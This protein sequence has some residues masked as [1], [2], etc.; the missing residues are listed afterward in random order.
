MTNHLEPVTE[1]TKCDEC[2][3]DA[4]CTFVSD[5]CDDNGNVNSLSLCDTCLNELVNSPFNV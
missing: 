1:E 3:E 4:T 5:T 2:G